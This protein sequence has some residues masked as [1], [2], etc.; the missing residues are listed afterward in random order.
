MWTWKKSPH[1]TI[2]LYFPWKHQA[3]C[4]L[5]YWL[6]F[7][8][9]KRTGMLS[10]TLLHF[11][12]VFVNYLD[13][14]FRNFEHLFTTFYRFSFLRLSTLVEVFTILKSVIQCFVNL[15]L[16]W[17]LEIY[18]EYWIKRV[19]GIISSVSYC[20]RVWWPEFYLVTRKTH[21][22][23]YVVKLYEIFWIIWSHNPPLISLLRVWDLLLRNG[24]TC[25]I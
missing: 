12:N 15:T 5:L 25:F 3:R 2:Q 14:K 13:F 17:K 1:D 9:Q 4:L 8:K 20:N 18:F 7:R 6:N 21:N 19:I 24:P 23:T 22:A 11:G 10:I 16:F